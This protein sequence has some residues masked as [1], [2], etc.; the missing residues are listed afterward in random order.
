MKNYSQKTNKQMTRYRTSSTFR[1]NIKFNQTVITRNS[2]NGIGKRF[3]KRFTS[4]VT[5]NDTK[6]TII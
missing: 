4:N 6:K 1:G 2:S 3:D 5:P